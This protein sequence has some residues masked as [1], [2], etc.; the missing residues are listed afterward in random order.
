MLIDIIDLG[1]TSLTKEDFTN[2]NNLVQARNICRAS[3]YFTYV[4]WY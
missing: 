2:V 1:Q 3:N 4:I